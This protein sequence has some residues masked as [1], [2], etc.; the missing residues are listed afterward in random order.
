M[1]K[2]FIYFCA[3]M[4]LLGALLSIL[5][6][7]RVLIFYRKEIREDKSPEVYMFFVAPVFLFLF[8]W[9]SVAKLIDMWEDI[10]KIKAFEKFTD[11]NKK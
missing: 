7:I 5:M 1:W 11:T 3:G 9:F 8:G 6:F 4:H 10:N 2:Y